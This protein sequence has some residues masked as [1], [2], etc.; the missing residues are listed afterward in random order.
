[1]GKRFAP[2]EFECTTE[3]DS[4]TRLIPLS[5]QQIALL[6]L[7]NRIVMEILCCQKV[8]EMPLRDA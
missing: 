7:L 5:I 1:V 6:S 2:L 4:T 8:T 3:V